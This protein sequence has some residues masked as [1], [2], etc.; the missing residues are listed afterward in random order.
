MITKKL[1]LASLIAIMTMFFSCSRG[2]KKSGGNEDQASIS[3][4]ADINSKSNKKISDPLLLPAL[5]NTPQEQL[6]VRT[7]YITS[8]NKTTR[9]PNWV[10]WHLTASHTNGP[11]TRKGRQFR[12]DHEVP[13]PRA[14]DSDYRGSG[15]DRGHMCPSGDNRWDSKAQD[16]TFIFTNICPQSHNLNEGVWNDL[17]MKCREWAKRYGDIYIVCGPIIR[18]GNHKTIGRNKVVVPDAF[19]KVVLCTKGSPKAIGFIYENE[20]GY[21]PM[22]YYMRTVDEV[23]RITGID[24]FPALPDN[25]EKK[26][27]AEKIML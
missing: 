24:F 6:L 9:L 16:D 15:Y 2:E 8:Y 26:I 25:I 13:S 23:E 19:F 20:D 1:C 7:G 12:E 10:A 4:L 11:H 27:E 5:M 14:Y 17:E 18:Q 22:K 21:K 3:S